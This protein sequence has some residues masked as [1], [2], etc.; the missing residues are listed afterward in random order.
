MRFPMIHS[1]D[2]LED[3][4][5]EVG[6]LPFFTNAVPGYSIEE[7]TPRKLWF[8]DDV[9]GPWEWKG[10]IALRKNCAYG[11]FFQG[12][13]GFISMEHFPA[14]LNYRRDGYDF[15]ARWD[16]ELASA[17]D[18]QIMDVFAE[19]ASMMTHELK[20]ACNYGK[21]GQKGFE[22]VITRLQMQTYVTVQNFEHKTD[23]NGNPYGWGVARYT[24]PEA[25]FGT[26]MIENAYREEPADSA[27]R[28]AAHLAKLLP[29]ASDIQIRKI[30]G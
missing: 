11:K 19:R 12:K 10:P 9:D 4:I 8:N 13:A 23:K 26:E 29:D 14:F 18:K 30:L 6:F 28:I 20:A 5:R 15:D 24:T 3:L 7:C 1:M 21:H 25:L 22:T 17:K 2:E 27:K 16:D